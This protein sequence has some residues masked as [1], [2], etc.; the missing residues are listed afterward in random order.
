MPRRGRAAGPPRAPPMRPGF[1]WTGRLPRPARYT[2]PCWRRGGMEP[3]D[4]GAR[5]GPACDEAELLALQSAQGLFRPS[6]LRVKRIFDVIVSAAFLIVG[7]PL[8][9][10]IA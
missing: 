10:A 1:V 8:G 4:I 2:Q 7:L 6:A 5:V 3:E 9:L